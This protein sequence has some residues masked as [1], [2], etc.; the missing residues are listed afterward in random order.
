M[1]KE[2]LLAAS[3]LTGA[4]TFAQFT[5]TNEPAIG[6]GSTLYVIDS[7]APSFENETGASA[8]WDYSTYGGYDGESRTLT[9]LSL[10]Q[11]GYATEF[12]TSDK[13]L[14][15]QGFLKAFTTSTATERISQ[16]FVYNDATLGDVVVQLDTDESTQYEY[17]F[18]LNDNFTDTHEGTASYSLQGTPTTSPAVGSLTVSVDGTGTLTLADNVS[19]SNV[20]RYKLVET[21]EI[22]TVLGN[23]VMD[24]TQYEY[25]DLDNSTLPVLVH[26][27]V[28]LSNS[29]SSVTEFNLVLSAEDPAYTLDIK[30][31]NILADTRVYPNPANEEI[32]VVLPN[33]IEEASIAIV[34]A[35]GRQVYI[36]TVNP[37]NQTVN[38]SSLNEGIYFVKINN[39]EFAAT[40]TVVV[41]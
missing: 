21:T 12:P 19:Y 22:S 36:G 8:N 40:K 31:N 25:Y 7:M 20:T 33:S 38:V 23:F 37:M 10:A 27:Y 39:G 29:G 28:N 41:K 5:Q 4:T 3:L 17:P 35:V 6:D 18:A 13:A 1:K 32:N 9:M 14:D 26:T 2:L 34:D 16:G 30:E 11:S 24:R 15:I